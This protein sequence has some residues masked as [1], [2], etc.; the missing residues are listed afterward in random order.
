MLLLK[1]SRLRRIR[2]RRKTKLIN[3]SVTL[4]ESDEI[5]I[6]ISMPTVQIQSAGSAGTLSLWIRI[7]VSQNTSRRFE[8]LLVAGTAVLSKYIVVGFAV[9]CYSNNQ[10]IQIKL[11]QNVLLLR[12]ALY[13]P[14]HYISK[15][16]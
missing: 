12:V 7:S 15:V 3:T 4:S 8:E 6:S 10:K 2:I 14:G 11:N 16:T 13:G 5:T 1:I 9:S